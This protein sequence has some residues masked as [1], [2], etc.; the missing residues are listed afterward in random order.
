[1]TASDKTW[2]VEAEFASVAGGG[3]DDDM[4]IFAVNRG[5][6]GSGRKA[7]G[8]QPGNSVWLCTCDAARLLT[9]GGEACNAASESADMPKRS[10]CAITASGATVVATAALA[11]PVTETDSESLSMRH[12]RLR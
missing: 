6:C 9:P 4:S 11:E 2:S 8:Y 1:M 12:G 7:A 10:V 5:I 3:V